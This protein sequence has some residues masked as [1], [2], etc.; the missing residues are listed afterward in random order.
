VIFIGAAGLKHRMQEFLAE[1]QLLERPSL[2]H[3]VSALRTL[4]ERGLDLETVGLPS[5]LSVRI[6]NVLTKADGLVQ[7]RNERLAHGYVASDS[8]YSNVYDL[9]SPAIMEIEKSLTPAL[10]RLSCCQVVE[11]RKLNETEYRVKVKLMVGDHPDFDTQE[12][13]YRPE[14]SES[15]P[16]SDQCYLHSQHTEKWIALHPYVQFKE[17]PTCGHDRVLI[18]D[19]RQY[20]DPYMAIESRLTELLTEQFRLTFVL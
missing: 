10:I 9:W 12:F 7:Q 3:W 1:R 18:T 19:G 2:G 11:M 14:S 15:I 6:R 5:D 4:T 8:E 16:C 17:C 13:S 20:L